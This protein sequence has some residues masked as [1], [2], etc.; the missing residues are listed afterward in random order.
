VAREPE[1]TLRFLAAP[2][3]TGHSGGVDGGRVQEWID[4]AAHALAASWSG[5]YSVTACV[6]HVRFTRPVVTGHLIEVTARL[7]HAGRSCLHI[8]TTVRS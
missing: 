8:E 2:T 4:K 1:M 6:G 7:V 5:R 3:D